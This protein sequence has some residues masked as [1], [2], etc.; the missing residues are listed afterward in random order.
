MQIT[1]YH[2]C[3]MGATHFTVKTEIYDDVMQHLKNFGIH[4]IGCKDDGEL[5]RISV[6]VGIDDVNEAMADFERYMMPPDDWGR[7]ESLRGK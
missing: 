7:I 2:E 6:Y 4:G 3:D 1:D 5:S